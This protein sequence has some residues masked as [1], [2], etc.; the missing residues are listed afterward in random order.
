MSIG[1]RF[2]RKLQDVLVRL[3]AHVASDHHLLVSRLKLKLRSWTEGKKQR[4]EYDTFLFNDTNKW[5]EFSIVPH[6]KFQALQELREEET[7]DVRW[8]RVK[9]VVTWTSNELLGTRNPNHEE[10]IS[11]ETDND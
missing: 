5:G 9:R 10:W 1:K 6:N 11:T 7:I 2:R 3:E 8:Q 4:L